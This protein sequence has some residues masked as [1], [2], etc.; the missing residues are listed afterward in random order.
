M[1]WGCQAGLKRAIMRLYRSQVPVIASKI[2]SSLISDGDI[3]VERTDIPEVELDIRAIMEEYLRG[4]AKLVEK[5]REIMEKQ[6]LAYSEFAKTKRTLAEEQK[7]PVGDD[8]LF[9]MA[10][11]IIES[12]MISD[13]VAEVYAPDNLMRRKII[14]VFR[15]NMVD[16]A[17]LDK[18]ARSKMKNLDESSPEWKIE[19]QRVLKQVRQ[20]RGLI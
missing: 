5:T 12:F 11:Q 6:N 1:L 4:Q 17:E 3:D 8:A 18:E 2:V 20:R 16:E 7:F 15:N 14:S 13:H 9:W 10:G 19:Y